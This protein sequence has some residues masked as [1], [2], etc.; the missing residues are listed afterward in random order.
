LQL[1]PYLFQLIKDELIRSKL[2]LR[3]NT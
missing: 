2:D 1:N 3:A